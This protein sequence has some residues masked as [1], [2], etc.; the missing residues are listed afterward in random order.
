MLMLVLLGEGLFYLVFL[1]H[2]PG[3][4][5]LLLVFLVRVIL[6]RVGLGHVFLVLGLAGTVG[7]SLGDR[8]HALVA[9][10]RRVLSRVGRSVS[11]LGLGDCLFV[12]T[13]LAW[14]L[15]CPGWIVLAFR[16]LGLFRPAVA[17]FLLASL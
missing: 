5:F 9:L 8:F 2:A 3:D 4:G 11:G 15:A 17:I 1:A 12:L 7:L 16:R 6:L 13:V 10:L 14:F